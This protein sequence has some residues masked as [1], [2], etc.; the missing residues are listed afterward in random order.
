[1]SYSA[2]YKE[3]KT[4]QFIKKA[5][6]IFVFLLIPDKYKSMNQQHQQPHAHP[7]VPMKVPLSHGNTHSLVLSSFMPA[8]NSEI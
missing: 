4:Q 8:R 5:G 6:H 2:T 1:M 3:K 7:P